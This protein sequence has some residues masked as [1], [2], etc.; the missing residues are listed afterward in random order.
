MSWSEE[1]HGKN[2]RWRKWLVKGAVL[3]GIALAIGGVI[4][5]NNF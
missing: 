1:S 5:V 4:W 3:F 2:P